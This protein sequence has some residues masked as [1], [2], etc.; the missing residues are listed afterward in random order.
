MNR[1]QGVV[2]ARWECDGS[3]FFVIGGTT[4]AMAVWPQPQPSSSLA[5]PRPL[6]A[7]PGV[8]GAETGA[9]AGSALEPRSATGVELAPAVLLTLRA[10]GPACGWP[11]ARCFASDISHIIPPWVV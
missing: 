4:G 11:I 3:N 7:Q 1:L 6:G 5:G 9:A 10:G 2:S 8:T